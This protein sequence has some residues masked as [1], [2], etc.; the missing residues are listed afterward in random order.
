MAS[1]GWLLRRLWLTPVPGWV[2]RLGPADRRHCSGGRWACGRQRW[3]NAKFMISLFTAAP[4]MNLADADV[5]S[6]V[7]GHRL[8]HK[9]L[10]HAFGFPVYI[11]NQSLMIIIAGALM[12]IIFPAMAIRMKRNPVPTGIFNMLEAMLD[13]LRR[14]IFDPM[15]G[16]W[17]ET[18]TPYLWTCFFFILLCNLM[19]MLPVNEVIQ[20]VNHYTNLAIPEFWGGP[21][22]NVTVTACLAICT[23]L[24]VHVT[25][26]IEHIRIARHAKRHGMDEH[27]LGEGR[28]VAAKNS[29][30]P[31]DRIAC[32]VA[33]KPLAWPLALPVGIFIY[34]KGMV[35]TVPL[36]WLLGPIFFVLEL[37]STLVKPLSLT[38]RL[39]AV[40]MSGPLV[41]AVFVSMI[42]LAAGYVARSLI[43][44]P[45]V[46]FGTAFESLHLLEAFLQAFI[47]TLLSAAYI[48][49]AVIRDH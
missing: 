28:H 9:P 2:K 46:L 6:G 32:E 15:L 31:D 7:V 38:M 12:L 14:E 22:G 27:P 49:E 24:T 47:F 11:T 13:F 30:A 10:F 8:I 20:M 45:V 29:G 41:I 16:P 34:F 19:G 17:A 3:D 33:P 44:I 21:T 36:P 26:V 48:A 25:G 18:F 35:P 37:L 5:L 4:F 43:G 23:F 1:A 40:M 42:F 39:F